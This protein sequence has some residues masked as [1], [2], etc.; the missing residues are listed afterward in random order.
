M[1]PSYFRL[2]VC[3]TTKRGGKWARV[4]IQWLAG[5]W[6]LRTRPPRTWLILKK[7]APSGRKTSRPF[8]SLVSPKL[9]LLKINRVIQSHSSSIKSQRLTAIWANCAKNWIWVMT[10]TTSKKKS[11]KSLLWSRMSVKN[12]TQTKQLKTWLRA[13]ICQHWIPSQSLRRSG[14]ANLDQ[15]EAQSF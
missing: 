1:C 7:K 5:T 8:P 15:I 10:E 12:S 3:R 9:L 2:L 6:P 11:Y 4:Q 13:G 14:Q